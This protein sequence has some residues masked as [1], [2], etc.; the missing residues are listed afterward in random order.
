MTED[1]GVALDKKLKAAY[2]SVVSNTVL[3]V[4]KI[5]IGIFANSLAILSEGIH[6]SFDLIASLIATY[7]VRKSV[8]PP[9]GKHPFGHGKIENLSGV[10]EGILITI[11]GA[12]IICEAV[13][14]FISQK[15]IELLGW[16]VAIMFISMAANFF[17][18]GYLF[19]VAGETDSMA[20]KADAWHL[21]TD[22]YTSMGVFIGLVII[23]ITGMVWLDPLIAIGVAVWIII[24][25]IKLIRESGGSL[26]DESLPKEEEILIKEIISRHCFIEFHALRTRKAGSERHIDLHLV[27]HGDT[28]TKT[29]HDI[30]DHLEQEIQEKLPNCIVLIH[31]EPR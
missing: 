12:I 8:K 24:I 7:S 10:I 9:D 6:S 18:S 14:K 21:R 28:P 5:L 3:T 25:S 19:K 15:G 29:A 13:N 31:I 11:A 30:C 26:L 20:L 16:G 23:K 4:S 2:L 27:I 17:I 22:F 1:P